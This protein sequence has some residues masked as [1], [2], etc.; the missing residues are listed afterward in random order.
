MELTKEYFDKNMLYVGIVDGL[1]LST[2]IFIAVKV[3]LL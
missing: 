3:L 2:V 1:I